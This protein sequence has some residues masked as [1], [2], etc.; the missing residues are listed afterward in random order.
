MSE[1]RLMTFAEA[2]REALD[3]ALERYPEMYVIGEGVPDPKA[4]F[5]TT[6]GLRERHGAD[7]VMDMPL[8]E[9]GMTGVA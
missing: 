2:I 6:K 7:R 4:I 1:Q 5:G 8:S 3:L 9:N